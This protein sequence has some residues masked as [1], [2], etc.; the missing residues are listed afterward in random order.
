MKYTRQCFSGALSSL[1]DDDE[2]NFEDPS[3]FYDPPIVSGPEWT[4]V[5]IDFSAFGKPDDNLTGITNRTVNPADHP[6]GAAD[7]ARYY[8]GSSEE[9][10]VAALPFRRPD[11][12]AE[13]SS[14]F[15]VLNDVAQIPHLVT[16]GGRVV[17]KLPRLMS[18]RVLSG[19]KSAF[20]ARAGEP[21]GPPKELYGF[22]VQ[23]GAMTP[24][25]TPQ[26]DDAERAP[27]SV[28]PLL[29][30]AADHRPQLPTQSKD[31]SK[32]FVRANS[33]ALSVK[34]GNELTQLLRS[35]VDVLGS[36]DD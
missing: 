25:T 7:A 17:V 36:Q 4:Q 8:A 10:L 30:P 19:F 22:L 20:L 35:V 1:L 9:G 3:I 14:M 2:R 21:M 24:T 32:A 15:A 11:S 31:W 27:Y 6:V 23:M 29:G 5:E 34:P 18:R 33:A 12:V 28:T 26:F 13:D 16:F